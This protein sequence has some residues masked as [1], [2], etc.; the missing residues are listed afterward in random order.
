MSAVHRGQHLDDVAL[1]WH[2]LAE[3]RLAYYTELL[4]SG[5]W[6]RYYA[7][8]RAFAVRMFDVIKAARVWARIAGRQSAAAQPASSAERD[9]LRSAA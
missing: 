3:R 7:D 4:I 6:R 9:H 2:H 8:E 5:R 1:R